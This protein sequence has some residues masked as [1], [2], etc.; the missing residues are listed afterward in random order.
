MS[1]PNASVSVTAQSP[2]GSSR[3]FETRVRIDTPS[4]LEIYRNGGI[5]HLVVRQILAPSNS[6]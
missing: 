2:D 6:A 3:E 1:H 4:E 5:L